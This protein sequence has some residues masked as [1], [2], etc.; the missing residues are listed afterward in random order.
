MLIN[1]YTPPSVLLVGTESWLSSVATS[2]EGTAETLHCAQTVE[3]GLGRLRNES[4][5]ISCIVSAYTIPDGDGISLLRAVRS[6][7]AQ[8]PVILYP[9]NG[10]ESLASN[11]IAAGTTDYIV[12]SGDIPDLQ[13]Q[14]RVEQ[15]LT[16][17]KREEDKIQQAEQFEIQFSDP[18]TAT[19]LLDSDGFIHR[20]NDT[21]LELTDATSKSP[22]NKRLWDLPLWTQQ[23]DIRNIR[24]SFEAAVLGMPQT[25]ETTYDTPNGDSVVDLSIRA[26]PE[27]EKEARSVL[28][29]MKNISE[30]VEL[31]RDLRHSEQLHR[32]ILN[33]MNETILIADDDGE[34]TYICP[35]VRFIF[36][37]TAEEIEEIGT[38]SE[39]LGDGLFDTDDLDKKGIITNKEREVT[40]KYADEHTLL[41]NIKRVSINGGTTL[42][43]CRDITTRKQREEALSTLHDLARELLY[44]ESREEIAQSLVQHAR[45]A[46]PLEYIEY[47]S[48]DERT[49][50]LHSSASSDSLKTPQKSDTRIELSEENVVSQAF[51]EGRLM[52]T[53]EGIE[54]P[55][56][57]PSDLRSS[58]AVPIG[59]EGVL[60][61]SSTTPDSLNDVVREITDLLGATAEAAFDRVQRDEKLH[62][63][64]RELQQRNRRLSKLNRIN[65]II[66][67]IDQELVTART[68]EG[69][70]YAVCERLTASDRFNFAWIGFP[71]ESTGQV[72]PQAWAGRGMEYLNSTFS[73]DVPHEEPTAQA[74]ETRQATVVSNIAS[75]IHSE[76]WRSEA[77]AHGFRSALSLPLVHEEAFYGVVT[78]YA[79]QQEAFDETTLSVLNELS[80]TIAAAITAAKQRDALLSDTATELEYKTTDKESVLLQL[81][82]TADC[83]ICFDEGL[84]Q[85]S[86]GISAIAKVEQDSLDHLREA[87][88]SIVGVED[89]RVISESTDGGA[90]SVQLR[91]SNPF[92]ATKLIDHGAILREISV[93][94]EAMRLK[95]EVPH[96]TATRPI[97]NILSN[98]FKDLSLITQYGRQRSNDIRDLARP[99]I[100]DQL[101]DRQLEV[102]RT[103]YLSGYFETPR[104][105]TGSEVAETL[106]V[107]PSA[108]SQ[109]NRTVQRKIFS[110]LLEPES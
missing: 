63:R 104:E 78:V 81:A 57:Q 84:Q 88:I 44:T 29:T 80:E 67:E 49:N 27:G 22:K 25:L 85:T 82:R 83:A 54:S 20:M 51:L 13:L 94:P 9:R 108:F 75:K 34:F 62:K 12:P 45:R 60:F 101:T 41:I 23:R 5:D 35:N 17:A 48:L 46:L 15:V 71:G 3:E 98:E 52:I 77:L 100:F 10:S 97:N 24:N 18:L 79:S 105:S 95:I 90:S 33:N 47:Y 7:H 93:N 103:A 19:I 37:Y 92:I 76:T 86:Q 89:F 72:I 61:A 50:V 42:I 38:I 74:A 65:D 102:V 99:Q 21:A 110:T 58:L 56:I 16:N 96:P 32:V 40:D 91:F 6:T 30:R 55:V 107:S 70:E 68:Q 53:D 39:L 8:L 87:A 4:C 66:R 59:D 109:L 2:L 28:V 26:A 106:G 64:D 11:A 31:E 14:E 73:E 36:G 43:S 69:I 1:S